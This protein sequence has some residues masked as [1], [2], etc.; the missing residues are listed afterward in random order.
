MFQQ[1]TARSTQPFVGKTPYAIYRKIEECRPALP[2]KLVSA[3]ARDLIAGLLVKDR[4][5]RLGE[6][7]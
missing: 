4:T 6:L 1:V 3:D 7:S 5:K 2:P